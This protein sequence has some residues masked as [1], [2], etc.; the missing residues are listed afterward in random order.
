[1][2][3]K[4]FEQQADLLGDEFPNVPMK[5]TKREDIIESRNELDF[6]QMSRGLREAT[7]N[8]SPERRNLAAARMAALAG[9]LAE[10]STSFFEMLRRL[11]IPY[12]E[13]FDVNGR[14]AIVIALEDIAE[15]DMRKNLK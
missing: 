14:K 4:G 11:H 5:Q 13:G 1:M 2:T 9:K 8:P 10:E 12:T 3:D 15:S 7:E 6:A